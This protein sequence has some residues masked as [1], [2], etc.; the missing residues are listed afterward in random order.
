MTDASSQ[1]ELPTAFEMLESVL[2]LI[3]GAVVAAPMLPGFTLCVPALAAVAVVVLA[4]VVAVAAVVTLVGAILAVP[5]LLVRSLGSIRWHRVAP[6]RRAGE[7]GGR[8]DGRLG[9]RHVSG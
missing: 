1:S 8:P 7:A 6:T 2:L 5:Y 3:T 9:W 4:P